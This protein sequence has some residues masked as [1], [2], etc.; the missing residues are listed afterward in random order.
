MWFLDMWFHHKLVFK[1]GPAKV[2]F[3]PQN[4]PDTG[5][6]IVFRILRN[7]CRHH[8]LQIG[9]HFENNF[10]SLILTM[11]HNIYILES[12]YF[13]KQYTTGGQRNLGR[14]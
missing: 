1:T 9:I 14:V 11:L 8:I 2:Y 12:F 3:L 10:P 13:V 6:F 5:I 4:I 7:F